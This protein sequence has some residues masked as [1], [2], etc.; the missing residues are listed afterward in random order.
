MGLSTLLAASLLA[1]LL[2]GS[3]CGNIRISPRP[4]HSHTHTE[5]HIHPQLLL[6]CPSVYLRVERRTYHHQW[7]SKSFRLWLSDQICRLCT[8]PYICPHVC[9]CM[10]ACVCKMKD[11]F[12]S[13]AK[14]HREVTADTNWPNLSGG[15]IRN[16]F[17]RQGCHLRRH[18]HIHIHTYR[19]TFSYA[20]VRV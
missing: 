4:S 20:H 11:F 3:Q 2:P 19:H 12:C 7:P 6:A 13:Q 15:A 9:A 18:I 17:A 5:T 8:C 16:R 1:V 14:S 10:C